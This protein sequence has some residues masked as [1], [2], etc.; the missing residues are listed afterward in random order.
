MIPVMYPLQSELIIKA[1]HS[2][3]GN[4][5]P[6]EII[7]ST[8]MDPFQP[9]MHRAGIKS[10]HPK[11]MRNRELIQSKRGLAMANHRDTVVFRVA[12]SRALKKLQTSRQWQQ[13]S[14]DERERLKDKVVIAL[15]KKYEKRK[16]DHEMEWIRRVE[17]NEVDIVEN[18]EMT[19]IAE[20]KATATTAAMK[21]E[22]D[23]IIM[24]TD[25]DRT[26]NEMIESDY[27]EWDGIADDGNSSNVNTADN[28][29]GIV[30]ETENDRENYQAR[31]M[32][33]IAAIHERYKLSWIKKFNKFEKM[34]LSDWGHAENQESG[35]IYEGHL[36]S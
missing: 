15:Q 14:M 23:A 35:S 31:C 27:E 25:V 10:N 12:K 20:A 8:S 17:A 7:H 3:F 28:W 1:K 32:E 5:Q 2:R 6:L 24:I 30:E 16:R 26:E 18:G 22:I 33:D 29:Q 4:S 19:I 11:T 9:K 34:A 13:A 36:F 21:D